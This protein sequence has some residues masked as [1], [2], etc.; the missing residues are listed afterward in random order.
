[1]TGAVAAAAGADN[2]GTSGAPGAMTWSNI[3]GVRSG[4]NNAQTISGVTGTI[5]LAAANSGPASLYYGLNGTL[6]L[7]TAPFAVSNGNTLYWTV[8]SD[9]A[10]DTGTIAITNASAGGAAVASFN[11]VLTG[12]GYGGHP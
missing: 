8:I 4:T 11:Y 1:M 7:Y 2:E 9:G 12:G 6:A 3:F 5:L 10:T